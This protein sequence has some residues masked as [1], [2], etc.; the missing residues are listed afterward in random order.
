MDMPRGRR[1]I[2]LLIAVSAR[3]EPPAILT[4]TDQSVVTGPV[5]QVIGRAASQAQLLMNGRPVEIQH[6]GPGAILARITVSP[7]KHEL[8]L[9]DNEGQ[10]AVSFMA[11]PASQAGAPFR[12]HPPLEVTCEG[13]HAVKDNTWALKRTTTASLCF[14]CHERSKFPAAHTHGTDILA[15]CQVCHLPHGSA[16]K[17][18]L[19]RPK[20]AACRQCHS[21]AIE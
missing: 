2:L 5:L 11:D 18:H 13:C 7:G 8:L 10:T 3:A 16:A 21:L 15:D 1:L 6:V 20:A 17:A 4:P 12:P 14:S 19:R 9:R